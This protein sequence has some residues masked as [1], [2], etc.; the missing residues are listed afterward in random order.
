MIASFTSLSRRPQCGGNVVDR[1]S[2]RYGRLL[3]IRREGS[4]GTSAAWLCRCDCGRDRVVSSNGLRGGTQS[5]G[6]SR[7]TGKGSRPG[8]K[9][10]LK[11]GISA[12][13]KRL[14][15]YRG[16]AK[17][18][19]LSWGLSES[20]FYEMVEQPCS[21]CGHTGRMV[22]S[23]S[24]NGS[25]ICNGID[26]LDNSQGYTPD[27]T[28]ACCSICNHAKATMSEGEFRSWLREVCNHLFAAK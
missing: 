7:K 4:R 25:F 12:K 1:A 17:R 11:P 2:H 5:C 16:S 28:V 15:A 14:K 9:C 26:R 18:R 10:R 20:Q 24:R 8:Y 27:N 19:G 3:V 21:Y 22:A 23:V 6:C 13:R